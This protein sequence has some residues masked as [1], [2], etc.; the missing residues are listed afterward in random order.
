[1]SLL[2]VLYAVVFVLALLVCWRLWTVAAAQ[3]NAATGQPV[4]ALGAAEGDAAVTLVEFMDYRCAAC[5]ATHAA[6]MQALAENPDARLV[7]RHLPGFGTP[8]VVEAQM[9]I[10]AARHGK[11]REMHDILIARESPVAE[12]EIA[13]I[14]AQLGLDAATFRDE[15]R[16]EGNRLH[17]LQTVDIAETLHITATPTFLAGRR[18]LAPGAQPLTAADI[19]AFIAA[20]RDE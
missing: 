18:R 20:T 17:M 8:S 12:E 5:R 4:M 2:R 10:T 11:F 7:V 3:G 15:M 6:V 9:A 14:A 1:M 16:Q 19:G 13:P